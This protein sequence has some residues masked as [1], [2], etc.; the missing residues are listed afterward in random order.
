MTKEELHTRFEEAFK[1][2][3]QANQEF[4]PDVLL[5]FYALYK[6]ATQEN[7]LTYNESEHE[8]V[9]AFKTNA[10]LQVKSMTSDEAKE[11]YIEASL[12]YLK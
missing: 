11:A 9:S 2:V 5:K 10:L 6:Q 12:K 1:E 4:A 8:L 7:T 3:S